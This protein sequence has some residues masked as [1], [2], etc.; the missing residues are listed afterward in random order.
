MRFFAFGNGWILAALLF[1]FQED[2]VIKETHQQISSV[3]FS[4][5]GKLLI[6]ADFEGKVYYWDLGQKKIIGSF[7][8]HLCTNT[9]VDEAPILGFIP[10]TS[11]LV[12]QS[13]DQTIK[14]WNFREKKL[15]KK[16]ENTRITNTLAFSGNGKKMAYV[17]ADRSLRV[18]ELPTG[19][20]IA[21]IMVEFAKENVDPYAIS[22]IALTPKSDFC[23]IGI[24]KVVSVHPPK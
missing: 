9:P 6:F 10:G 18:I 22:S 20:E 8:A 3:I 5:D 14:F 16:I 12:S 24:D 19:R 17:S 15:L 4:P 1:C 13:W 7:K 21:K 23:A 11:T 2:A